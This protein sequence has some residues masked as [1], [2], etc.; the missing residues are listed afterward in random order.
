MSELDSKYPG[1]GFASHKGYATPEHQ[2]AIRDLGPCPIHRRSFDYIRELRGEYCDLYY[3]LKQEGYACS[4]RA[5]LSTW[6][7][8]IKAAVE[9]FSI[10]ENK[11]L[12]L[13]ATRLWKR[14]ANAR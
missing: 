1:Y 14:M 10:N 6:E 11:K 13:M 5:E 2:Q 9:K 12:H 4:S 8:K 3:T 7:S